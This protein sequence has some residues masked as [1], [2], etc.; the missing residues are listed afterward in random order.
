M[1]KKAILKSF[2]SANYKATIQLPGSLPSWLENVP[3]SRAIP[4][5]EMVVGRWVALLLFDPS[6]PNDAVIVG[7][8][9]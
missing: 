1:I 7:V 3:V 2:D 8:Y 4:S 5:V 9:T 6:N